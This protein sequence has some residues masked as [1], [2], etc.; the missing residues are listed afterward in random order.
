MST[1][2]KVQVSLKRPACHSFGTAARHSNT[3]QNVRDTQGLYV[4]HDVG[5]HSQDTDQGA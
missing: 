2:A 5:L 3:E 1:V 4:L